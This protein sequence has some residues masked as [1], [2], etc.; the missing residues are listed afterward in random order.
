LS[1]SNHEYFGAPSGPAAGT[2]LQAWLDQA[3]HW[4]A[5]AD[6]TRAMTAPATRALLA[7]L[8][9]HPGER[10]LDVAAGCGDP[11]LAI[12]AQVGAGGAVTATDG[13]PEMVAALAQAA[14]SAGLSNVSTRLSSAE[15]LDVAPASH[16]AACCRFGVMFFA[17]PLAALRAMHRA[18][19]PG[20]RLAVMA[21]GAPA[22]NPYFTLAMEALDAAGAPPLQTPP[23]AK[24]VFEFGEPGR[25]AALARS[26]GW[27]SVTEESVR[28]TMDLADTTPDTALDTLA[29]LSTQVGKRLEDLGRTLRERARALLAEHVRPF[30]RGPVVAFP[31]QALLVAGRA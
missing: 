23:G 16:D 10:V 9:L 6:R 19:R 30:V 4:I 21:W 26:A 17:D 8:D 13:V 18:V 29:A 5:R 2:E 7:S 3:A 20:G 31:A 25:L 11:A 14:Q 22:A 27:Q 15:S 28:F 24:T 1:L 12:A